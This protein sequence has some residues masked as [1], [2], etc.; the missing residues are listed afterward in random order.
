VLNGGNP[1]A[2]ADPAEVGEYPVGTL[3]DR[4]WRGAAYDFGE[5]FSPDG[6][7]EYRSATFGGALQGRLLI[8]RYSAGDDIIVL[9]PGGANGDIV[10]A[11][12][13]LP[14]M[15]GFTDPLDLV[16]DRATGRLYVSEYGAQRITLLRPVGG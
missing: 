13:G 7:I 6:A 14:G 15:T 8:A 16:E 10:S 2:A 3:P 1:T 12:T 9:E 11:Q 5:H 4:N